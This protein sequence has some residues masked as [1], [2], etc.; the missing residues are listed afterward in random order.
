MR[1]EKENFSY[2]C[3]SRKRGGVRG[4]NVVGRGFNKFQQK[5]ANEAKLGA[6]Y[7]DPEHCAFLGKLF[8][9]SKEEETCVLE[10]SV[11][12]GLAVK[13]VTG[14]ME[15]PKI[16]IFADELDDSVAAGLKGDRC[17]EKI[18][19][20]DFKSDVYISNNAFTF[21]FGNPPYMDEL[22]FERSY[23]AKVERTEKVFLDK[24]TNYLK[25]GGIICWVIPHRVFIED[26]Y[27]SFWMARYET[28]AVYKFHEKEFAKWGQVALIGKKRPYK[29]GIT[30]ESRIPFQER[31]RLENLPEVP[32]TEPS[33]KIVVPSSPTT[34]I[35]KF[36]TIRFDAK[37]ADE[38]VKE[39]PEVVANL[40]ASIAV[41]TG[42]KSYDD[43]Q[44]YEPPKKLSGQNLALLTACGVGSGYAGSV[45]EGTLHLQRGSVSIV[46]ER[47]IE[48]GSVNDRSATLVERTRSTTNIVL[49]ESD[50]TIRDLVKA[51]ETEVE[52]EEG[53]EDYC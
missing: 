14:A 53:E 52:V 39:H 20:A 19:T 42:L 46:T 17:F 49:I 10:P 12:N 26:T 6:Y 28:L 51:Q 41:C 21:C 2:K 32:F 48:K 16:R 15:N 36:Q 33:E 3:I 31:F 35:A 13:L 45:E 29:V 34:G 38:Y 47:H 44:I 40:N 11:G 25:P 7:T 8:E 4:M 27:T 1:Y 23:G 22:N 24:V 30:K 18:L 50:G 5:Q 9:F 37:A 43:T